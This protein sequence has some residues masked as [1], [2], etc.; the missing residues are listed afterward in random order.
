MAFGPKTI[1]EKEF[2][3][4]ALRGYSI[5]EVDEFLDEVADEVEKL[6]RA[7]RALEEK[8]VKLS[9]KDKSFTDMEVT[10]RDTLVTA[11]KAADDVVRSARAQAEAILADAENE[12]KRIIG[13]AEV[14]AQTASNQLGNIQGDVLRVKEA[15]RRALQDQ[16]RLLDVSYP[17]TSAA[18]KAAFSPEPPQKVTLGSPVGS[19]REFS[20]RD[21]LDSIEE[22]VSRESD[23]SAQK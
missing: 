11:Q 4:V 14:R 15:I 17:E 18:P 20:L 1:E 16:L 3:H 23:E 12:R 5:D 10:L 13:E 6:Q 22:R 8:L 19:T 7:N 9:E 2:K 21:T